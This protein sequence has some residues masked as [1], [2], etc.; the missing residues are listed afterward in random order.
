[1]SDPSLHELA[2]RQAI[3]DQLS[4]YCR[5]LDRMPVGPVSRGDVDKESRRDGDPSFELLPRMEAP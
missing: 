1:M 5:G 4:R 2:A 3:R